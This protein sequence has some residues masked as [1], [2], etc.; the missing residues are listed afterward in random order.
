MDWNCD[1]I[2]YLR[3]RLG[4]TKSDLARRLHCEVES[5]ASWEDGTIKPNYHM[6]AELDLLEKHAEENSKEIQALPIL[7]QRLEIECIEQIH[8]QK[9]ENNQL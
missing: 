9:I 4:W 8:L 3:L 7:E 5:I 1:S 6:T 2:R